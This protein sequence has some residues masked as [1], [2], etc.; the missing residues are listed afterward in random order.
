MVMRIKTMNMK[1]CDTVLGT[2]SIVKLDESE[3]I[4]KL[5]KVFLP[6]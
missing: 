1:A 5:E 4:S 2:W 3:T 6:A